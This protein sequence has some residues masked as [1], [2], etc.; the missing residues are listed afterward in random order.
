MVRFSIGLAAERLG[1]SISTLRRW[2][3]DG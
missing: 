2:E 3:R 1:V